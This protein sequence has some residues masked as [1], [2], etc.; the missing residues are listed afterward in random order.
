MNIDEKSEQKLPGFTFNKNPNKRSFV[1][2]VLDMS[3]AS[4]YNIVGLLEDLEDIPG[5]V[6]VIFNSP[7]MSEQLKDHPRIDYYA[8]MKKNVGV[9]RAWNIG[10]NISQ[11]PVTFIM[12]SDLHVSRETIEQMEKYLF[13][14]P[15]AAIVGPQGSFF[16]FETAKDMFYLNKGTFKN[17]VV[18]DAVSGFLFAVKTELFNSGVIKFDNQYTPCYFEEWDLGLQIKQQDLK[19]YAV[20]VNGFEHEWS[21]SIRALRRISYLN[22]EE[23]S[24]E[25]LERNRKLFWS[26]WNGIR[27]LEGDDST[28]LDSY[29]KGLLLKQ[30]DEL[31]SKNQITAAENILR[32]ISRQYPKDKE[33]LEKLGLILYRSNK[34]N[35]ALEVFENIKAIDPDYQIHTGG[36]DSNDQTPGQRK[37]FMKIKED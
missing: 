10:L 6:I 11:T 23:A 28:L 18:V 36:F 8:T 7:E 34:L 25:I 1:I 12:N 26:K 19:S 30:A 31:I 9:S 27:F 37:G 14:L 5:E 22:K 2:P 3:P 24:G 32:E 21:G 4:P 15:E 33:I 35:E 16:N 17:P 29:L 20:P 13:R